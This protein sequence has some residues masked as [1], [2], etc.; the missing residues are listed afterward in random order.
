MDSAADSLPSAE[1]S[2]APR[3]DTAACRP[4]P[5]TR[6]E[7]LRL[8]S[9][10]VQGRVAAFCKRYCFDNRARYQCTVD[11][12][13]GLSRPDSSLCEWG[14]ATYLWMME[15]LASERKLELLRDKGIVQVDQYWRKV[16]TSQ[17][18]WE[19]FK[20]WRFRRRVRVPAYVKA[21]DPDAH[22]VFWALCDGDSPANIAQRLGR[23]EPEIANIAMHIRQELARRGRSELLSPARLVPL[24]S[25]DVENEDTCDIDL[26][27][28]NIS[29]ENTDLCSRL[30]QAYSALTWQEQFLIDSMIVDELRAADVLRALQQQNLSLDEI[31]PAHAL[32]VQHVYYHLRKTIAKLRRLAGV[33][34]DFAP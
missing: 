4:P 14:N 34:K 12:H 22:R 30:A 10:T 31:L 17:L 23:S 15:D 9:E 1:S 29:H 28:E 13:W 20:D 3:N 21:I 19:R 11:K 2:A 25:I 8:A 27:A 32:N 26:P 18:F 7:L 24:H 33:D 6:A 16:V 5:L